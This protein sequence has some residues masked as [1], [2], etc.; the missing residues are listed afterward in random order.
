M[1]F[2]DGHSPLMSSIERLIHKLS[3][4][5]DV[6]IHEKSRRRFIRLQIVGVRFVQPTTTGTTMPENIGIDIPAGQIARIQFTP[7]NELGA[8]AKIDGAITATV[9]D[10]AEAAEVAVGGKDG[11]FLDIKL[12]DT[13][14]SIATVEV[15]GDAD[16]DPAKREVLTTIITARRLG[17]VPGKAI[18]LGGK[19]ENVNFV[20]A[21]Q[22][23]NFPEAP[24]ARRK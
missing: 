20:D 16:L 14:G 17:A 10:D 2:G 11:L 9:L 7:V 21:G 6:I 4:L 13:E 23:G 19:P 12:P 8:A 24:A 15:D 18:S 1:N 5:C 3:E 22:F